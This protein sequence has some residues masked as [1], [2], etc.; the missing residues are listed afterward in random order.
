MFMRYFS[1]G[2]GHLGQQSSRIHWEV[3][4]DDDSDEGL[5]GTA[6]VPQMEHPDMVMVDSDKDLNGSDSD[7]TELD[8]KP[9]SGIHDDF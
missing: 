5:A 8:C 7:D 1:W 3:A 2:I 6:Q 4:D 9:D